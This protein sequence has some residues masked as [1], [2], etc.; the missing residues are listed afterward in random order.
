MMFKGL[1]IP[2]SL[3][4]FRVWALKNRLIERRV[5]STKSRSVHRVVDSRYTVEALGTWGCP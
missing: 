4:R 3:V 5:K 1:K 2:V